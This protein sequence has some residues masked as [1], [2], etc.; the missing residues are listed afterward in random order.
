MAK[1]KFLQK[2]TIQIKAL[3]WSKLYGNDNAWLFI[4]GISK[5][6]GLKKKE[7]KIKNKLLNVVHTLTK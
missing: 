7:Q 1:K 2:P 5:L 6:L 3:I 4:H